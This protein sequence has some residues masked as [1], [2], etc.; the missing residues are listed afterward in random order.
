MKIMNNPNTLS[1]D[2]IIQEKTVLD[3]LR[4]A[5][6]SRTGKALGATAGFLLV[7][8]T[9]SA[10]DNGNVAPSNTTATIEQSATP[11]PT[12]SAEVVNLQDL[13]PNV[14]AVRATIDETKYQIPYRADYTATELA[15]LSMDL[16]FNV[17]EMFNGDA[18]L[19]V[20]DRGKYVE[21]QVNETGEINSTAYVEALNEVQV[22][23]AKDNIISKDY[24][25]NLQPGDF[26][27]IDKTIVISGSNTIENEGNAMYDGEVYDISGKLLENSPIIN[28]LD[29]GDI[30][31]SYVFYETT[32]AIGNTGETTT[33]FQ[34]KINYVNE[35][36]LL[37]ISTMEID[38]I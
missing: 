21:A 38:R 31:C 34:V 29:N 18:K 4:D 24:L 9:V 25:A 36:G 16:D 8:G 37:K 5:A 12:Q 23:I 22:G 13:L 33:K 20:D 14:E 28:Y 11:S 3:K 17:R 2:K 32:S 26:N 30:Y 7:A 6:R 1:T 19:L 15:T 35:D 10:C 27:F